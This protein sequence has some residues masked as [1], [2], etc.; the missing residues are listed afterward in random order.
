M[1]LQ[2]ERH[3]FSLEEYEQ[4]IEAGVFKEDSRLELI[5]GEILEMTPIG[6]DHEMCVARLTQLLILRAGAGAV[7]WPQN[8]SIRLL[9]NSRPQPDFALLKVRADFS[10]E[11]PPTAEDVLLVV[12]VANTS[13]NYDR[14]TKAPLYAEAGIPEYWIVNLREGVIEVYTEPAN[15]AYRQ[16]KTA[17]RGDALALPTEIGGSIEVSEIVGPGGDA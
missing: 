14:S 6:F 7:V 4:M 16:T 3:L 2:V 10:A 9:G 5:R 17:K 8:N 13:L 1:A 12:E 15:G 11:K